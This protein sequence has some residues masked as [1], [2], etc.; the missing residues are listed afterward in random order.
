MVMFVYLRVELKLKTSVRRS[1][2]TPLLTHYVP[3]FWG[4]FQSIDMDV[5]TSHWSNGCFGSQLP[6][7]N[8]MERY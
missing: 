2:E 3:F 5:P 1:M 6:T 4:V 8:I 7:S